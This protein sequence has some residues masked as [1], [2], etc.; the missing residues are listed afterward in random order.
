MQIML[1]VILIL[2]QICLWKVEVHS[3]LTKKGIYSNKET[4]KNGTADWW[5]MLPDRFTAWYDNGPDQNLF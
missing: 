3:R 1:K 4:W 5:L 2:L